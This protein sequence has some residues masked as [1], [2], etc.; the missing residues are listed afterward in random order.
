VKISYNIVVLVKISYNI[1]VLVKISYNIVLCNKM[2]TLY[3]KTC[4]LLGKKT[5]VDCL[6]YKIIITNETKPNTLKWSL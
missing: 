4:I 2:Y 3:Y 6:Q 5:R 1:V